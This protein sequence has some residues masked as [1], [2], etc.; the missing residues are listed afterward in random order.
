MTKAVKLYLA[1]DLEV[2][3]AIATHKLAIVAE[4]GAGKTYTAGVLVEQLLAAG[5]QVIVLEPV[6]VWPGLK[7]SADGKRPGFAI[8]V[9]GGDHG[10]LP[11]TPESAAVVARML[12][13][14]GV[15]AVLD[16]SGFTT[17][18]TK[19]FMRDFAEAFFQAKKKNKS[20]VHLVFEEAQTYAP[21]KP[22]RDEG[23][24]LNRVERLLKIGRN[25]GVGW[26]LVTQAPQSVHKRVLNLAGTLIALRMTGRHERKA[27]SEWATSNAVDDVDLMG[28]LPGLETGEAHVWS[29]SFLKVS[30]RVRINKKT[31][32]DLSAT[33]EFGEV[34]LEPKVLAQVDIE[35]LR[36]AMG[37]VVA[38]AEKDDPKALHRRIAQL[39]R[40]L[41]AKPAAAPPPPPIEK[42]VSIKAEVDALGRLLEGFKGQ[43]AGLG[44]T[45]D[46]LVK[47]L[48]AAAADLAPVWYETP[49]AHAPPPPP[50]N[51][52]VVEDKRLPRPAPVEGE[53]APKEYEL[54]LLRELAAR[55]PLKPTRTQL[56][57]LAGKSTRSSTFDTAMAA[58]SKFR[59]VTSSRGMFE[60]TAR[61]LAL[62]G[63]G[64]LQPK[65][66]AEV[67]ETWRRALKEYP[68]GLFDALVAAHPGGLTRTE[69]AEK[70][71]VSQTSSTFDTAVSLL[72]KNELVEDEGGVLRAS[73]TLFV[74][75]T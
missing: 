50:T 62:V 72:K 1:K 21:Q 49:R 14:R 23:V 63:G 32:F 66:A 7:S 38:E 52:R 17:G 37:T 70:A 22:E 36:A 9:L 68:R 15:S 60:L 18:E 28:E 64:A 11:L 19:V 48:I 43:V 16:M 4:S 73:A 54:D 20:P 27:L 42:P 58:L 5:V 29:P 33:P 10:D 47:A 31:T 55:R 35:E 56:A 8:L 61:G 40:E 2:P 24:M 3:L 13:E 65:S 6:G 12:A 51:L 30:K 57:A 44:T 67:R 74:E 59:W 69:L 25:F 45:H 71:K 26:T 53:R 34:A 75:T 39:E 46:A 41:A